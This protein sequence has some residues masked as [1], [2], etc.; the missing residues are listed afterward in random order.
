MVHRNV[1]VG[2]IAMFSGAAAFQAPMGLRLGRSS[3]TL[4][5][6][7]AGLRMQV[8]ESKVTLGLAEPYLKDIKEAKQ[9]FALLQSKTYSPFSADQTKQVT[10]ALD[11]LGSSIM[12][13]A[14]NDG[15]Y[16]GGD[17]VSTW[18]YTKVM[19]NGG[20]SEFSEKVN[21]RV[22]QVAFPCVLL[23]SFDGDFLDLLSDQP[24]SAT[25]WTWL[26]V[27]GSTM[28]YGE[29]P[30]ISGDPVAKFM[31]TLPAD[32]KTTALE[33]MGKVKAIF[34]EEAELTNSRAAM[35][36]MGVWIMTA[37]VF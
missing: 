7:S 27:F 33:V 9:A 25:F 28:T 3:P 15:K 19:K 35:A 13:A 37:Y 24:L 14:E 6:S 18:L 30:S 22:A 16:L 20:F 11:S 2:C 29:G 31:D 10:G 21:G 32:S 17:V 26:I 1:L 34:T 36:A 23:Q 5:R 4:A 8:D 12:K